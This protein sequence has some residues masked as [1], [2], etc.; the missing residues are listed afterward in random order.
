MP[1]LIGNVPVDTTVPAAP[2]T[3]D[4]V[5]KHYNQQLA[6]QQANQAPP[7]IP[8]AVQPVPQMATIGQAAPPP[9][10]TPFSIP[11]YGQGMK[12]KGK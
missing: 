1:D 8:L 5:I 12:S 6:A 10:L 11:A 4:L 7:E 2:T 9:P 3:A